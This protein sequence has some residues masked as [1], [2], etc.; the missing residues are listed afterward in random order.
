MLIK[1]KRFS[2]L[3]TQP[4]LFHYIKDK[5]DPSV[6]EGV[7]WSFLRHPIR[8]LKEEWTSIPS[9]PSLFH[10]LEPEQK[11]PFSWKEFLGDLFTGFRNPIFIPSVFSKPDEWVLERAQ[12]RTRKMEAGTL[13]I[14]AH[15][16]VIG[17]LLLVM[18]E[19]EQPASTSNEN[20]VFINNPIALPYEGSDGQEGGGGGGGGKNQPLPPATGR[21]PETTR[22]QL[23][24]PDPDNP[25]PLMP[26]EDIMSQ[27]AS[28]QMPIDIPQDQLLPIG[29]VAPPNYS[30]SSGPGSGGGIGTG[31]GTGL[32]S[33]SGAG[34]G[35]GSGGGM[36]GGSGGGIGSGVGPYVVGNGVK[37]P[38]L[39]A[40]TRPYYTEEAR[41]SRTEGIV[42]LE[43]IVRKDGTPDSFRVLR[44]LG[45]GLDESAIST[46]A[47]KWRFK[48]GTFNGVPADVLIKVEVSFRLY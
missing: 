3:K 38:V 40:E 20:V 15:G 34:V 1:I 43:L 35:P 17:L 23:V 28:V 26:I 18:H 13:S 31:R 44:G 33:G 22:V 9:T 36:G 8:A 37:P 4:S 29:D 19:A 27:Q 25:K 32:G 10:Y 14:F 16:L 46:I 30:T 24:P 41:K 48:P 21:M 11:T 7:D 47:N 45:Y 42:L 2:E 12:G 6:W 39:I 5:P